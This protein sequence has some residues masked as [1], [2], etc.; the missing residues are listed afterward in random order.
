MTPHAHTRA[1]HQQRRHTHTHPPHP[2]RTQPSSPQSY[3][4][5]PS[6]R[7]SLYPSAPR[8]TTCAIGPMSAAAADSAAQRDVT[9]ARH[10][11]PYRLTYSNSTHTLDW[12]GLSRLT[13][14]ESTL[15]HR[16]SFM[17]ARFE[18]CVWR[19]VCCC[20]WTSGLTAVVARSW[21]AASAAVHKLLDLNRRR[22]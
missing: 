21:P 22:S 16:C 5:S 1:R 15:E 12:P 13:S 3:D 10:V 14:H 6:S 9:Y 8:A 17:I 11:E 2:A 20:R 18:R 7:F 4:A 19:S